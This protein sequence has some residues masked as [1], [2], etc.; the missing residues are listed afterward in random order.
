MTRIEMTDSVGSVVTREPDLSRIFESLG[1]DYCCGGK[2]SIQEACATKGLDPNHILRQLSEAQATRSGNGGSNPATM[3]LTELADHI[4]ETHHA[5]LRSE[6]PRLDRLTK[7]VAAV[8]GDREPALHELRDVF[9]S[10]S[11]ELT[12]HMFKEERILFPMIRD[13]EASDTA[14]V[15]HCGSLAN[16][17]G[18]M[19]MEHDIAGSA[20]ERQRSLT[21]GYQPPEWACN[22]FR[23]MVDALSQLERDL[24]EHIHKENNVLFPKALELEARKS[25]RV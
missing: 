3:T 18:Q 15:F 21:D 24:H 6:L 2:K 7:K 22:T 12:R 19:E 8:H 23:A 4:E 5:Y 17:I 1:I 25:A 11:E 9:L 10:L 14:P 13:L 16:P 20:L